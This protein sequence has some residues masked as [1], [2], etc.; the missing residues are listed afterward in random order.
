[1][2]AIAPRGSYDTLHHE[3]TKEHEVP[4]IKNV[5]ELR[6]VLRAFVIR[7]SENTPATDHDRCHR[8]KGASRSEY[9]KPKLPIA[10]SND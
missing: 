1:M 7:R 10:S 4:V 5:R 9:E 8:A 3:D 6:G 2:H